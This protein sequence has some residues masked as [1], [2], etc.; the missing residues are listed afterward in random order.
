MTLIDSQLS[1][2]T[3]RD[4]FLQNGLTVPAGPRPSFDRAALAISAAA[5]GM[6]M[7]LESTRLAARELARGDLVEFGAG[8]FKPIRR[9]THFYSQRANQGHIA[10]VAAFREW[11]FAQLEE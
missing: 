7:T 6:G 9:E 3:W 2:V 1:Q 10:K 4:W 5:D 8:Q 11:L